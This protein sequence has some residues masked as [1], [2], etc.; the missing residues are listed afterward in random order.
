MLKKRMPKEIND[1]RVKE[2]YS[3]WLYSL[4][5]LL[6]PVPNSYPN[7][8]RGK[9]Y[10]FLRL[11][12]YLASYTELKHDTVL[13]AKQGV[14]EMGGP[15]YEDT[16]IEIDTR[17]YVIPE[18]E[19]YQ[20]V[21]Q[22]LKSIRAGLAKRQLMPL[23]TNKPMV[24]LEKLVASLAEISHKE[25]NGQMLSKE[26]YQLIEFIGGDLE[27]FW[28]ETILVGKNNPEDMLLNENNAQLIAD[29]FT[30]PG[31]YLHVATGYVHPIYV[32]FSIEGKPRIGRGGVMSYYEMILGE[33]LNDQIWR[34]QL[35]KRPQRPAWVN[36]FISEDKAKEV[37]LYYAGM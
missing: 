2:V 6:T 5:S 9:A 31:S 15:D 14:A 17:G 10:P 8:M 12:T 16:E 25:L 11:N 21:Y 37:S 7:F 28:K 36:N 29:I 33:R 34:E 22:L 1:R 20:R 4:N 27:H 24:R 35:R 3:D 23:N 26:E 30:G 18:F 19:L 32:I 13:Y